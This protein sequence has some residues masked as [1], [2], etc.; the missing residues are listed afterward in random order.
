MSTVQ[1]NDVVSF[2]S[3]FRDSSHRELFPTEL[4]DFLVKRHEKFNHR[5]LQLLEARTLRQE[6]YDRGGLPDFED[7]TSEA[8]TGT[9]SVAP[10][11]RDLRCRRVEITGIA[12]I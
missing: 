4:L 1:I 3:K 8:V 11:P 10:I 7:R 2:S 9:W 5:R 6:R 12:L